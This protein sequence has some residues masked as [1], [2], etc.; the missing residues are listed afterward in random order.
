MDLLV[1]T[2]KEY[3][4]SKVLRLCARDSVMSSTPDSSTGNQKFE[5]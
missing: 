4:D 5:S 2:N 1:Y 3:K